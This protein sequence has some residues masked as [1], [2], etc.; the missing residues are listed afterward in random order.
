MPLD[1]QFPN[2][3]FPP[4][5]RQEMRDL[6]EGKR[7]VRPSVVTCG[8]WLHLDELSEDKHPA[9]IALH[10]DHPCDIQHFYMRKPKLFGEPGD[11]FCWCDVKDADPHLHREPGAFVGIDEENSIEWDIINQIS[12]LSPDPDYP[13]LLDLAP[14]PDG[15]YRVMSISPFL[16]NRHWDYR[17]I[18]NS[19]M[20]LYLEGDN[21]HKL[22]RKLIDFMKRVI[23]RAALT[24]DIDAVC[25]P[26]DLGMQ[27]GPFMSE[28][29]FREFYF[30]YY[31][32]VFDY[33][34]SFNM[35]VWL[36]C[37]GD[38]TLLI[39]SLI[40]SGVDVLHPIQKFAMNER[41]IFAKYKDKLCFWVGVDLQQILPYGSI[42][43]VA[44]EVRFITDV[45]WQPGK[46]RLIMSVSNR[47]QDNVPLE[48]YLSLIKESYVYGQKVV[49][50]GKQNHLSI[51]ES[52]PDRWLQNH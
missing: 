39:D 35:H 38:I 10:K 32:E 5:S 11:P 20:D 19:L 30:P 26:D 44:Q 28:E 29:L 22:N 37:C 15:R 46:G 12:P 41:E 8:H 42:E 50:E 4:L 51:A 7:G 45:F 33:V 6:I 16:F 13:P 48:N 25:F 52:D 24:K 47:I 23:E 43:D 40:E 1:K 34:H 36:H 14:E 9:I 3:M 17:G 31:K 2:A 27:K 49:N 21:I 18:T